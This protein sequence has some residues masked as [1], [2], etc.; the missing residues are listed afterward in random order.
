MPHQISF[1]SLMSTVTVLATLFAFVPTPRVVAQPHCDALTEL[2]SNANQSTL[3]G[4]C[5]RDADCTMITCMILDITTRKFVQEAQLRVL[6]CTVPMPQVEFKLLNDDGAR[7]MQL[8]NSTSQV[9][10]MIS[11]NGLNIEIG[12]LISFVNHTANAIGIMMEL[13]PPSQQV[14]VTLFNFTTVLLDLSACPTIDPTTRDQATTG[15]VTN[16]G[17]TRDQATT[18]TVT[19]SGT[20]CFSYSK[21][22]LVIESLLLFAVLFV[23]RM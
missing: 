11:T 1:T 7:F 13:L 15:T 8:V 5:T 14:P 18:G 2:A 3:L 20:Q 12:T 9:P 23:D 19:N 21:I 17:T 22:W 10:I 6:P 4:S 16:S